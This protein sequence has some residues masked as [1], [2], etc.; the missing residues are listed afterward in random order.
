MAEGVREA[1][2][3]YKDSANAKAN[4]G[5]VNGLISALQSGEKGSINVY[6]GGK[7]IANEVYEPLMNI[8]KNKEVIVGA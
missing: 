8:M 2:I 5:L 1:Q 3:S 6:I 7:L 4:T